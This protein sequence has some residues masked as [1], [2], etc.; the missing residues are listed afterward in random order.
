MAIWN[1][2][3]KRVLVTGC[4][5]GIGLAQAKAFLDQGAIVYGIDIQVCPLA[6]SEAF[7]FYQLD[8]LDSQQLER[9]IDNFDSIDILLN[10]AGIL[11]DYQPIL[12]TSQLAFEKVM[13][14]NLTSM[15]MVTRQV[16]PKMLAQKSG[17]IIN[18]C[19][20][21][22]LVAGGGGIAYTTSKHAVAGFTKQL[23][24][25]YAKDN[26]KVNAIAPGAIK[27]PMN[28]R[29]FSGAGEMAQWVAGET[30]VNRWGTA[31]EVANLSLFL[32][33]ESSDYIQGAIM[34]ID[35]GWT[36]K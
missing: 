13:A 10:T 20:I 15:F 29:D 7:K 1:F 21:A 36:L 12:M 4:S 18:M 19:S 14:T 24:L 25:D 31:E 11:D 28:A 26:L 16:L 17:T 3:N 27:T 32:A 30:P 33:S 5:S 8:I 2:K 35:G 23:A 9:V 6:E 22:G 34:P